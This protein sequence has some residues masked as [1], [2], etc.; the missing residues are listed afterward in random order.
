MRQIHIL[1]LFVLAG[2][3][4]IKSSAQNLGIHPTTL[5][6]KLEKGQNESQVIHMTNGS[7]K[8]IQFRLYLNDWLRDS[9]G[10]HA[11]F[12]ADTLHHSC[13][14]WVTID[15]SFV[16]VQPGKSEDVT[17]KLS[18]PDSI[19]AVD[20][21]KWSMLFIETVEEQNQ[22]ASKGAQAAV[23]NLLRMGVHIYQ[24]PPSVRKKEIKVIDLTKVANEANQYQVLCENTGD[25]ML[26]CSSYMKL[27]NMADGKEI[28]LDPVDY[29]LFPDQR[30]Y[31]KFELPKD[32]PKGIG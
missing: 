11:Y 21:M 29:P 8:K 27:N 9:T 22:A 25:V 28:K 2:F 10:G 14:R 18:M 30:R 12:R 20:E 16:E 7:D 15:K 13:S 19:N 23:R 1:F 26:D 3:I 31:V 4:S 6:Y 32:L 17:V 5:E 24:T